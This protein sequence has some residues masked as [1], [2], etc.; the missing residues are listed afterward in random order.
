V[1]F[2]SVCAEADVDENVSP[3]LK[4]TNNGRHRSSNARRH[5][6]CFNI[7]YIN[8]KAIQK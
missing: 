2:F 5:E 1:N 6:F 4:C 3:S 7:E 8:Y